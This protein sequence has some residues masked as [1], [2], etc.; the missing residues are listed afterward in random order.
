MDFTFS[1]EQD[2]LRDVARSFLAAEA[3]GTYVRAMMDDDRGFTDGFWSKL[4]DLGW[5]GLFVPE[6]NGGSGLG[7]L[8]AVVVAEEMGKLP[9]PSPWLSSSVAATLTALR[10]GDTAVLDDLAAGRVRGTLAVEES[11]ERNPLESIHVTARQ[12]AEGWVLDGVKPLVLDGHSADFAY[13]VARTDDDGR[14]AT[15]AVDNPNGTLVPTLDVT[16]KM[17]R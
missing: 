8:E 5:A 4:V 15:F 6:A 17:A 7:M 9:L 1:A 2:A 11:G 10:L 14:L 12:S 3:P 16:R 13:V